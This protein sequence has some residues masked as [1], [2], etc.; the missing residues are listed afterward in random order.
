MSNNIKDRPE[1]FWS[2]LEPVFLD[3]ARGRRVL[4]GIADKIMACHVFIPITPHQEAPS[5]KC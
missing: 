4:L 5:Q 2:V 1:C 3:A